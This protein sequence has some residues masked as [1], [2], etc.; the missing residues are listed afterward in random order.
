MR[1]PGACAGNRSSPKLTHGAL[2]VRIKT[3]YSY[4]KAL[5]VTC[6]LSRG[7]VFCN[8]FALGIKAVVCGDC[9]C[10]ALSL[11]AVDLA[12]LHDEHHAAHCADVFERVAVGG[13]QIC[14]E[15][16]SDCTDLSS[17]TERIRRN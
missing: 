17:Q 16:S 12:A 8:S 1:Q 15:P 10:E 14:L 13:Y 11:V 9:R 4:V 2:T 5:G 7:L 3:N 6:R